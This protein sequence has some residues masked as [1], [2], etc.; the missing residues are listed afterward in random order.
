MARPDTHRL[1]LTLALLAVAVLAG[2]LLTWRAA[3]SGPAGVTP[4]GAAPPLRLY[5]NPGTTTPQIPLWAA[6]RAGRLESVFAVQ[7]Q[8][9]KTT[10][11]LQGLLLAGAGD[12]WIGH[13]D[14]F[15]RARQRG[16]P[17]V[18]LAVTGWRKFALVSTDPAIT[19]L[20]DFR[21]R[22]LPYA[23][24]GSPAVDIVRAILPETAAAITFDPHEPRQLALKVLQGKAH[25]A[26]LPE[27]LVTTML[28]QV[29]ALRV[30]VQLEDEYARR[31]GGAARLPIA[32]LAV[33]ARLV[34][35]DPERVEALLQAV[36]AAGAEMAADPEHAAEVLPPE[37]AEFVPREVVRQSLARD[38]ILAHAARD[39]AAEIESYLR[40]VTPELFADGAGL[41]P[42]FLWAGTAPR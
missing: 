25:S 38:V 37:F 31:R 22:S 39:V 14:G 41:D 35:A 21:Q 4:T 23:P 2:G 11:H 28:Q 6:V 10:D 24:F 29:P 32:G 18:L 19:G 3:R 12:A 16:A 8:L 1:R 5:V 9:W 15:A 40:I 13:I 30:V 20:D 34:Q 36:L 33:H 7:S 17:V 26:L 27:P 42:A